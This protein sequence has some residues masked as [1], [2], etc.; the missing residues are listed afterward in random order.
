MNAPDSQCPFCEH[1]LQRAGELCPKCGESTSG[2]AVR[3]V[4]EVDVAHAGETWDIAHEK[5][6]NAVNRGV[7]LGHSGVKIIHGWGASTGRAVISGRAVRLLDSLVAR[8]GG[9]L[10]QDRNN[11]GAHILWLNR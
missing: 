4:L 2:R 5:I 7:M 6:L 11:P 3:G 10:V 9:K 8:T 1:P